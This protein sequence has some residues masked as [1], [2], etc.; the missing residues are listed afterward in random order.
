[1]RQPVA[2]RL[3]AHLS[4]LGSDP[5]DSRDIA[6][7]KRLV[8]F[9]TLLPAPTGLIWGLMY[10]AAGAPLPALI[11]AGYTFVAIANTALFA[12][13]R[14]LPLYRFSQL[15]LILVLPWL[16]GLS[17]GGFA[18]S[19]AVIV[20]SALAPLAALLFED[21]RRAILWML[22]FT[23]LVG[24]T[25]AAQPYLL[26]GP[27][28][29]PLRLWFF[30]LN[31]VAVI[32]ITFVLLTY[33]VR[34]RDF[35][36]ARAEALLLNVL[37]KEI[38][39]QLQDDSRTIANHH[40]AASI[41]FAD[42]V[43]FT[44][45]AATMT[46][47]QLVDLLNEVFQCFDTLVEKYDLE[48]IKTIGD[49]YM[50]AAGVPRARADHAAAIVALA[51]DMQGAVATHPFCGHHLRFRIGINSG[52]VVAGVIGRKK[53]IYDLWG[54]AVNLAS[55]ME[56]HGSVGA[57]QITRATY[58]LVKDDFLCE[59]RARVHVKGAGE[60]EIWHVTGR[61]TGVAPSRRVGEETRRG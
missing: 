13:T 1:M 12:A 48:K 22:A 16:L 5:G 59:P 31:L 51:L 24:A 43:Q 29:E 58:E 8:L 28:P 6:L 25:A 41:L 40:D 14:N 27:V 20:W 42:V 34:Q 45:M 49:C 39:E 47:L 4:R 2:A 26:A 55:R 52:P 50:V 44:P 23:A 19:S 56:S 32:A 9:L 18:P 36:Q 54:D 11:P 53:F 60:T 37:P 21:F 7:E 61:K 15:L 38:S 10:V 3:V 57:I 33:F 46:P 17:L 35:F 30:A